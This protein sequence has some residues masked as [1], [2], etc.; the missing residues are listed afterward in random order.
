MAFLYWKNTSIFCEPGKAFAWRSSEKLKKVDC[1]IVTD[2]IPLSILYVH[3][4]TVHTPYLVE[5]VLAFLRT[6]SLDRWSRPSSMHGVEFT[7]WPCLI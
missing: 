4:S 3:T 7:P 6:Q 5:T 2:T 1:S